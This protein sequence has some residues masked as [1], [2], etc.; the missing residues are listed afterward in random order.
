LTSGSHE[1]VTGVNHPATFNGVVVAMDLTESFLDENR[2][3]LFLSVDGR[4]QMVL[5]RVGG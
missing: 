2:P 3:K 4:E 1:S 5:R